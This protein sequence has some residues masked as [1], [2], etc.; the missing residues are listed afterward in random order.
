MSIAFPFIDVTIDTKGL[1]PVAQRAPGVLAVVGAS[2]KGTAAVNTPV[3]VGSIAEAAAAFAE[4]GADG[5]VTTST[6]LYVGVRAALLQ[7]PRPSKIYGVKVSAAD[8]DGALA[9]LNAVDDITFVA[10]AGMVAKKPAGGETAAAKNPV[11]KALKDHV[12]AASADGLKRIGVFAIDPALAKSATYS[13]DALASVDGLKSTVS[14]LICVAARG[15][16]DAGSNPDVGCAVAS[17]IAGLPVAASVVL[18]K[19][20]GFTLPLAQQFSPT[21]VKALSNGQIIPIIDPALITGESL[22]F[23][24]GCC[25]TTDM[26]LKYVDVIRLLDDTEF[27]VKAGLIGM[28]GDARI[29]KSGLI[30]VVNR[31]QGIL[32]RL[33]GPGGID[34]YSVMI[35]VL[36]VLRVPDPARS[37]AES[38]AVAQARADRTVDMLVSI[39]LGPA[40]HLLNIAL[41]PRF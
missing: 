3:V 23:A 24:E 36:E 5:A 6:D 10:V 29:T 34:G 12:E 37:P 40:V 20:T 7:S 22:H 30:G 4:V 17:A 25:F 2:D 35:P 1:Q 38:Q 28:I 18:K 14:R 9:A 15:A 19:V 11:I 33:I 16:D 31:T 32:D 27:R 39:T 41:Q 26:S 13:A 21:E 8:Y